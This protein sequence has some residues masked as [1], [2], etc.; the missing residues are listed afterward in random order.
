M[1]NKFISRDTLRKCKARANETPN[2]RE[3]RLA[4]QRE[5]RQQKRAREDVEEREARLA[6]D[7]E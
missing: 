6:C 5:N 4:K 3:T 7:R 1:E 2:Q